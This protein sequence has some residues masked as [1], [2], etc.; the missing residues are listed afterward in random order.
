[1]FVLYSQNFAA[2]ALPILFNTLK[3][4]LLKSS[5]PKKYLPNFCTQKNPGIENFKPKK[6]LRSFP[7]LEIPS[8]PSGSP[9]ADT[10]VNSHELY[11][12]FSFT[13][14]GFSFSC[15]L[16]LTSGQLRSAVT[17]VFTSELIPLYG[18]SVP[19]FYR[20]NFVC[21]VSLV[22]LLICET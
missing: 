18:M 2:R 16:P 6:I 17:A 11:F 13:F 4:S 19:P 1:M 3:K 21:F 10:K 12:L 5:Y 7:S 9:A 20:S 14:L 22:K 8:T 15:C